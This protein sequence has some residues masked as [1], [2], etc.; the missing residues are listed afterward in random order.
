MKKRTCQ[1][2][3]SRGREMTVWKT[4]KEKR[5]SLSQTH[6]PLHWVAVQLCTHHTPLLANYLTKQR[7]TTDPRR[8]VSTETS[9]SQPGE[10]ALVWGFLKVLLSSEPQHQACQ[11]ALPK[12]NL[13]MEDSTEGRRFKKQMGEACMCK[14]AGHVDTW[15][16]RQN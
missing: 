7:S 6:F 15:R 12:R 10:S 9:E 3:Q 1:E 4:V 11:V 8:P 14:T 16:H 2:T 13:E 5:F